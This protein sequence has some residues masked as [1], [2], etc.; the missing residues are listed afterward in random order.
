MVVVVVVVVVVE[1]VVVVVGLRA[2]SM[3]AELP[4]GPEL[5]SD[6]GMVMGSPRI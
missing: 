1:V 3:Q 4:L 2:L 6:S 5:L